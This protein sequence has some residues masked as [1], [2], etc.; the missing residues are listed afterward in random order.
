MIW[1]NAEALLLS[2]RQDPEVAR[3]AGIY[4]KWASFSLP[5]YSFNC[6]SRLVFPLFSLYIVLTTSSSFSRYF[7]A[8]GKSDGLCSYRRAYLNQGLFDVPARIIC[9]VAPINMLLTYLLGEWL[10]I[11]YRITEDDG[12][13]QCGDLNRCGLVLLEHRS[14]LP[15]HII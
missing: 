13:V 1:L 10:L 3:L 14:Q 7:Q 11:G 12:M 4:L 5:G 8:Q 2:L 15:S 6:I 9:F